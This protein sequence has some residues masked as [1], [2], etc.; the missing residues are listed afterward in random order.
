MDLPDWY[1]RLRQ[2]QGLQEHEGPKFEW[3]SL[4]EFCGRFDISKEKALYEIKRYKLWGCGPN[5]F[6][7]GAIKAG[8]SLDAYI[9]PEPEADRYAAIL[10]AEKLATTPPIKHP[11]LDPGHPFFA[12]ELALA[13]EAWEYAVTQKPTATNFKQK[14]EAFLQH[15]D[16]GSNQLDRIKT[17]CGI[18]KRGPSSKK[19]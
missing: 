11:C 12:K 4:A 19:K 6:N 8:R 2:E 16:A 18:S 15:K 14:I 17:V 9:V 13:L 1:D 7:I 3:L 10:E 5:L